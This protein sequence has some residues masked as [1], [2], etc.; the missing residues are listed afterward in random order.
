M[1][2]LKKREDWSKIFSDPKYQRSLFFIVVVF[3]LLLAGVLIWS[4][5]TSIKGGEASV[6]YTVQATMLN[7]ASMYTDPEVIPFSATQ[8]NPFYYIIVSSVANFLSLTPGTD[9]V[10]I[11][12]VGRFI[13]FVSA[14][15]IAGFLFMTLANVFCL[16]RQWSFWLAVTS[17]LCA[18]PWFYALRPDSLMVFFLFG[19]LYFFLKSFA[20]SHKPFRYL[21]AAGMLA[22]LSFFSK[23]NGLLIAL[24]IG[25]YLVFNFKIKNLLWFVCGFALGGAISVLI[26]VPFY[27]PFFVKS[28]VQ[29][30]NNG[31]DVKQAINEPYFIFASRFGWLAIITLVLLFIVYTRYSL[32]SIT[33]PF[34]FLAYTLLILFPFSI[35]TALKIGSDINYFHEVIC[36]MLLLIGT[37]I[38]FIINDLDIQLYARLGALPFLL[39]FALAGSL[40]MSSFLQYGLRSIK[41]MNEQKLV[42]HEEML[43]YL[44]SELLK[45]KAPVFVMSDYTFV[46]NALPQSCVVPQPDISLLWY[47]HNVFEFSELKK[48]I[49]SGRIQFYAGDGFLLTCFNMDLAKDFKLVRRFD[50]YD[51]YVNKHFQP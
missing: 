25:S 26:F 1:E 3:N 35:L 2:N 28:I 4:P 32:Q 44:K 20:P 34:H 51:L 33:K 7:K 29:G 27:S 48:A 13:S 16:P 10:S 43:S 8:Y 45:S 31:I 18:V 49:A 12:R 17:I 24:I 5:V 9:V 36:V 41:R 19:S 15:G 40:S 21:L 30:I 6:M 42:Y 50:E 46:N 37:S 22:A 38:A 47:G 11:Y 39:V 14:L 23:Q